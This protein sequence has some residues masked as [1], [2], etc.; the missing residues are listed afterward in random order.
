MGENKMKQKIK[1]S[2]NEFDDSFEF[3]HGRFR[4]K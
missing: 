2:K 1:Q 4:I 3:G